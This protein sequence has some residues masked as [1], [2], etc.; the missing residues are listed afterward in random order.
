[1][2]KSDWSK[3]RENTF[4]PIR[5]QLV[6]AFCGIYF[7]YWLVKTCPNETKDPSADHVTAV[8]TLTLDLGPSWLHPLFAT[9]GK[10]L[11]GCPG[12]DS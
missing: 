8:D 2:L 7:L 12:H 4:G 5:F 6:S 3:K 1:M 9:N 10:L 11:K